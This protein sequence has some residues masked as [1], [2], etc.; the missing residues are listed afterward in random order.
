MKELL[1]VGRDF[2]LIGLGIVIFIGEKVRESLQ[3]IMESISPS[4]EERKR[5]TQELL[6]RGRLIKKEV[7]ERVGEEIRKIL[8][9]L[10]LSTGEDIKRVEKKLNELKKLLQK[11]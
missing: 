2:L 4:P 11:T 3:E 1:E 6:E 9:R 7:E 5:L 8:S 10:D